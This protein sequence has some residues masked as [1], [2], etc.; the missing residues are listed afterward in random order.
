MQKIH[1]RLIL[2][3]LGRPADHVTST[4]QAIVGKLKQEKGVTF[5]D[6]KLHEP[7]AVKDSKDMFTT[8]AEIE[9]YFDSLP[10]FFG[11][12]FAYMPSNIEIISPSNFKIPNEEITSLGNTLIGRLHLYESVTK[13]LVA[14]RDT[15]INRLKAIETAKTST[16]SAEK[17]P[18]KKK[19]H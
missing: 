7:H 12:I 14:D 16:G 6:A 19:K 2:E 18:S 10:V 5:I 9:T 15:L 17:K 4:L 11:I 1:A 3:I 13:K 8:F